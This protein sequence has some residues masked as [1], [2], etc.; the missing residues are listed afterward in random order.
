MW[1]S[2]PG[3]PRRFAPRNDDGLTLIELLIVLMLSS[4]IVEGL[5]SVYLHTKEH[6]IQHNAQQEITDENRFMNQL[7]AR[8]IQGAGYLGLTS[9]EKIPVYDDL[10]KKTLEKAI[11]ILDDQDESL[12]E[13]VRK[14]IKPATQ[15]IELKQ[16]HFNATS[17]VEKANL[18]QSEIIINANIDSG[19]KKSDEIIISD[20]E[21][22]EINQI[23]TIHKLS[24][25][26]QSIQLEMPLNNEYN[27]GTYVGAYLDKIYF[28]GDA[29]Q[30]FPDKQKIYGLYMYSENGMTEE[31][32]DLVSDMN[33]QWLQEKTLKISA[34]LTLPH[35][36]NGKIFSRQEEFIVANRE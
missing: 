24:N 34:T 35:W 18:N 11:I 27:S 12:P 28:I 2:K 7:F 23:L 14:K 3:L 20:Y 1:I 13:N 6:H 5:F 8:A 31:I 29:S 10:Q 16:M 33:F 26:T 36:V 15:A 9:W 4:V 22:A 21:H 19:L 25:Q 17:L 32:T 30:H